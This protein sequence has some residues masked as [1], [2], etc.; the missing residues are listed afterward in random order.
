MYFETDYDTFADIYDNEYKGYHAQRGDID[1]YKS[2][3]PINTPVLEM[4]CGTGRI[5][6]ELASAGHNVIALDKSKRM[7]EKANGKKHL[8]PSE[9]RDRI[10]FRH[11]DMR[12]FRFS[13]KFE[14]AF[15][16]FRSFMLLLTSKDQEKSLKN[17]HGHL[18]SDG[19]LVISMYVPTFE[20]RLAYSKTSK[21]EYHYFREF[22]HTDPGYRV[23]EYEKKSA[24]DFNQIACHELLHI[25][26]DS[27]GKEVERTNRQLTIRWTYRYEFEHLAE[28]CGYQIERLF[29][30]YSKSEFTKQ[31]TEMIWLLKKK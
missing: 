31:S 23:F 19:R 30:D 5:T 27:N 28:K 21:E 6:F 18:N 8:L 24:D 7:L 11:D 9:V 14:F 16:G 4:C 25:T 12:N 26:K 13:K 1:F 29:G 3:L 17:I 10:E 20:K 2:F 22:D 15:I